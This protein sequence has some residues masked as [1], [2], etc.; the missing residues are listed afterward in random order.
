VHTQHRS[1]PTTLTGEVLI[2]YLHQQR[3]GRAAKTVPPAADATDRHAPDSELTSTLV[4][5]ELPDRAITI[6]V[7]G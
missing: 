7:A 5:H 3:H 4:V 6:C 1:G 2:C